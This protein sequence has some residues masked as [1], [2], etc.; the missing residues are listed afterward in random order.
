M[1]PQNVSILAEFHSEF[2][3]PSYS[4]RKEQFV[5]YVFLHIATS[6]YMSQCNEKP[7]NSYRI[8]FNSMLKQSGNSDSRSLK[9][10]SASKPLWTMRDDQRITACVQK[11]VGQS[12]TGS[13]EGETIHASPTHPKKFHFGSKEGEACG[14]GAHQQQGQLFSSTSSLLFSLQRK[15][16][17]VTR[18]VQ[19]IKLLL[20]TS[21]WILRLHENL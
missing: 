3:V 11:N 20:V 7:D 4:H 14:G 1:W 6:I 2:K 13:A 9:G 17:Q 19:V 16:R 18:A 10:Y 21:P 8:Q 12:N 5:S 15:Q